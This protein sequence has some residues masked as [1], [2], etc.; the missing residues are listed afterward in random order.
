MQPK[1][2]NASRHFGDQ[3]SQHHHMSPKTPIDILVGEEK[4]VF[5]GWG[6]GGPPVV[7]GPRV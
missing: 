1:G 2:Q 7:C 6:G 4:P 3:V 5:L